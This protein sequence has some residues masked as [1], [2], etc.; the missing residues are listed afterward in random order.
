MQLMLIFGIGFSVGA[1][2]FALQNNVP[3]TVSFVFWSFESS[4]AMV[5]L[6]ALG[7]G[8]LITGLMS[9]PSVIRQQWASKRLR[10]QVSGLEAERDALARR[11]RDLEQQ[12][13]SLNHPAPEPSQPIAGLT[14]LL[15]GSAEE[16]RKD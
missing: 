15:G 7:L 3:V 16:R 5:L 12:F 10:R 9:S 14:T 6:L 13:A 1:V 2:A 4:L 11:V 8:A